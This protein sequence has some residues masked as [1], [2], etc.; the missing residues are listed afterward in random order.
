[1]A[2]GDMPPLHVH[3]RDDETFFVLEGSVRRAGTRIR[4][5]IQL[6]NGTTAIGAWGDVFDRTPDELL[7]LD[8]VLERLATEGQL[9]A[10]RH[11]GF[12]QPMDTLRD[13][14]Y[15]ESLWANGKAPWKKWD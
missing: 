8:E 9:A 14:Q 11:R 1:M 7:A 13:K 4:V 10:W 12:W 6:L 3:H 15:L 2:R 5:S